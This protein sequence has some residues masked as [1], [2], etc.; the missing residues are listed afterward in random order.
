MSIS[1]LGFGLSINKPAFTVEESKSLDTTMGEAVWQKSHIIKPF[2]GAQEG[3]HAPLGTG[4][5][6]ENQL[7]FK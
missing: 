2:P 4:S 5:E 1:S 3:T 6:L 7:S